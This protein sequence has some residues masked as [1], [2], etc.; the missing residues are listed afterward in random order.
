MKAKERKLRITNFRRKGGKKRRSDCLKAVCWILVPIVVTGLLLLDAFGI[1]S[2][3]TERLA[4]LGVVLLIVLL[5][6]FSEITVK[7]LSIKRD[8]HT[9]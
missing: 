8:K 6:F 1:Y 9:D 3:S 4:V 5:P 7:D 2:F